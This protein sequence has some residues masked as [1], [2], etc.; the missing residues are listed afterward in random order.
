MGSSDMAQP[1]FNDTPSHAE[2]TQQSGGRVIG[3]T[4]RVGMS[5]W[6]LQFANSVPNPTA[7]ANTETKIPNFS[8]HQ[9]AGLALGRLRGADDA[10]L[11][12]VQL[13][14]L[15]QLTLPPNGRVNAPQVRQRARIRQPVQHLR[16]SDAVVQRF[17]AL[18][19]RW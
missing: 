3:L 1:E 6:P 10:P 7:I 16:Q 2:T 14:R 17:A 8:A 5:K 18:T 9:P 15:G 19:G 11:G 13:P 4:S 12:V